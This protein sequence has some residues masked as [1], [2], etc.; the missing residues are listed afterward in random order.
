M[1]YKRSPH[2]DEDHVMALTIDCPNETCKA[3]VGEWCASG[4]QR[5][6]HTVRYLRAQER[7]DD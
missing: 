4:Q 7:Q 1:A 3:L 6:N 2:T 5:W